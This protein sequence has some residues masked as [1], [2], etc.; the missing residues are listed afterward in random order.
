MI[1]TIIA[2][3]RSG[4]VSLM[5]WIEKSLPEFTIAQ[6]PWFNENDLWIT[7]E[8]VS[9]VDWI[10]KYNNIC[11]REIYKPTR[12]FTNLINISDKVLCLYR[13]NWEEQV[14]SS[15]Y[16]ENNGSYMDTYDEEDVMNEVTSEMIKH[17]YVYYFKEHKDKFKQFIKENNFVSISYENLFYGDDVD[18]IKKHFNFDNNIEFPLNKRHLK[19]DGVPVELKKA[20]TNFI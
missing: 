3:P 7:G 11:I 5:N 17:R 20:K 18:I 2:E 13:D 14:R 16:Q 15:L 12:D 10:K 8:D 1:Y 9:E 19:R 6:E 4:G